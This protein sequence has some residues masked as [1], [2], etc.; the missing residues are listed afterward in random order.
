MKL[1]LI[2]SN[3]CNFNCKN[4]HVF[5]ITKKQY[6]E[7]LMSYDLMEESVKSFLS[8]AK[9]KNENVSVSLYGG[10]PLLNKKI[11]KLIENFSGES[12]NWIINTNGSLIND[13]NANF[14][15]KYNVDIHI[16]CD[17]EKEVNDRNRKI[18][19]K[20]SYELILNA[21][22]LLKQKKVRRQI[23]SYVMPENIDS[24]DSLIDIALEYGVKKIYLDLF[25]SETNNIDSKKLLDSY[26]N[27]LLTA[28][29]KGIKI[30]GPWLEAFLNYNKKEKKE[31]FNLVNNINVE[32]DGTFY[33]NNFPL[34]R[35]AGLKVSEMQSFFNS[36][37]HLFFSLAVKKYFKNKCSACPLVD[38]CQ[39]TAIFQYQYHTNK[40]EGYEF[41]C[42]FFQN[43]V[44]TLPSELKRL[45]SSSSLNLVH[46]AINYVC[47]RDC[48]YCYAKGLSNEYKDIMSVENFSKL[49][50]WLKNN[51]TYN[52]N[53]IGGE[54]SMNPNLEKF[55]EIGKSNNFRMGLFSNGIFN[56]KKLEFLKYISFFIINFNPKE[57]YSDVQYKILEENIL[58][59]NEMG[60]KIDLACN[61]SQTTKSVGHI[62]AMSKRIRINRIQMHLVSPNSFKN[63]NFIH[64]QEF[65]T[66]K[67]KMLGFIKE[68]Q[69]N[70][71]K[72]QV[73]RPLPRCIFSEDELKEFNDVL[74]HRC[75]T[76]NSIVLVNP[77]LT[78]FPCTSVFFKGPSIV[79][80]NN[81][82]EYQAYYRNT[83][84]KFNE[85][86]PLYEECHN[87]QYFGETC[88]GGCLNDRQIPFETRKG[89]GYLINSQVPLGDFENKLKRAI[90]SCLDFFG[91]R[92]IDLIVYL[93]K[94]R[95]Y[96]DLYA[97]DF[98]W[99]EWVGTFAYKSTGGGLYLYQV[100]ARDNRLR[101][102]ISHLF[103]YSFNSG[104]ISSWLSEGVCE[105]IEQPAYTKS[106][107]DYKERFVDFDLLR[108]V[109]FT[110][111]EISSNKP[112]K[113][114]AY[115]QSYF[116]VKYLLDSYGK[117]FIFK[118]LESSDIDSAFM[119][120]V[121]ESIDA[122]EKKWR[123][124]L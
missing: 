40:E 55:I 39:G 105:L 56:K 26:S 116:F 70:G 63:N 45:Y 62:I 91:D 9:N 23:N 19:E 2:V 72:V 79:E 71:I 88:L 87:C 77:D 74:Y 12:I 98:N 15:K 90:S 84:R 33:F 78:T 124:S 111:L 112:D 69:D 16:S 102:E 67:T 54:P 7:K 21:L 59:L 120:E 92:K 119:L 106:I 99:P 31:K 97:G 42:K 22:A 24:L 75:S 58:A 85:N 73:T 57:E 41:V 17:G 20:G 93:F 117:E 13:E 30:F 80:Y 10:E 46:V 51:D 32:T 95:L 37:K 107:D 100:G 123:K 61:I 115:I 86:F 122:V 83:I 103:I 18:G 43:F 121:N 53:F 34:S 60:A 6:K 66:Q 110:L 25:Y 64:K 29:E 113:N 82:E 52:L 28:N 44:P 81:I 89:D 35:K 104:R 49:V 3:I 94:N 108:G 65:G 48:S 118:L 76:G 114:I 50:G 5:E 27:V 8:L 36:D 38:S 4:C 47:N 1:R 109:K 101:H 68:L 11:Y 14:F 96:L